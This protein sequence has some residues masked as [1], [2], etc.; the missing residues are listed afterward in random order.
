MGRGPEENLVI[1]ATALAAEP[2]DPDA[3]SYRDAHPY[4]TFRQG[5]GRPYSA[6]FVRGLSLEFTGNW[7][8]GRVARL[9][10]AIGTRRWSLIESNR[11]L[12]QRPMPEG[13]R[14]IALDLLVHAY[15]ETMA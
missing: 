15:L 3:P 5:L 6:A 13:L 12:R 4:A 8:A 1:L 7:E 11:L 2:P 9:V 10:A 14:E